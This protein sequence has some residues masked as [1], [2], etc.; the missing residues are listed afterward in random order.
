[1][2][3][4][5]TF[6]GGALALS[7]AAPQRI[8]IG[9]QSIERAFEIRDAKVRTVS[10]ENKRTHRLYPVESS[11]FELKLAWER[12]GYD[13]GWE[14]PVTLTAKD[15]TLASFDQKPG[16]VVF[17]LSN[18]WLSIEADLTYTLAENDFF[19]RKQLAVRSA[20]RDTHFIEEI[21]LESMRLAGAA[22]EHGGFGQPLYAGDLFM[23]V[24]YPG[25][26]NTASDGKVRIWY[27]GGQTTSRTAF[28]TERAVVGAAGPGPVRTSFMEY[29]DRIRTGPVRPVTVFNTWYDMQH[30]MLTDAKALDRMSTLK[31]KLLDPFGLHLDTFV[32]DD[33]WDLHDKL[34]Q[35]H[36][37]RFQGD[38]SPLVKGLAGQ[39]TTL[40]LWYGPIGG[41]HT[42]REERLAAGR[43]DGYE[44]T[45]GGRY[46]CLAGPRYR[47]RF[48]NSVLD[49]VRRYHVTHF[50]FDGMS[51]GCNDPSH[52]HLLGVHSR[53][54]GLRAFIDVLK[55]IKAEDRR[56]FLNITTSIWLSPWWLEYS[57]VVFMGGLD[58][59]FLNNVPAL[60]ERE[61]AITYRDKVFYD[62]F[63]KYAYQFPQNS[64]MTIGIIKGTLGHEGGLGE[65]LASFTNNAIMNYSRGVMMTELYL[66]PSIITDPEWRALGGVMK[67]GQTN[68][69]VLLHDTRFIG[70]DPAERSIY[71]YAHFREGRGIVTLRNPVIE[72]QTYKLALGESSGV[73]DRSRTYRARVIYPFTA[74]LPGE[75]RYGDAPTFTLEGFEVQVIEFSADAFP[76]A[77]AAV[78]TPEPRFE[79]NAKSFNLTLAEPRR[80]AVLCESNGQLTP[81]LRANGQ[82]L[83]FK[84]VGPRTG[85]TDLSIGGG[86]WTFL[87]AELPAGEHRIEMDLPGATSAA[88]YLVAPTPIAATPIPAP[89]ARARRVVHLFTKY[90]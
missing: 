18:K 84:T 89:N 67:W 30:E 23:G 70:G 22:F 55:A 62:N 61:K 21:A 40:G 86:G 10:I 29:V 50:K 32:L 35:I 60:T 52:G 49:M 45:S 6:I 66:S 5:T 64:L 34:W 16:A 42:T 90:W 7:A 48:K 54:A 38:F 27:Y 37:T 43:R 68:A 2:R 4:L 80:L 78:A 71:G 73:M 65:T 14:N 9:N 88:A 75:Y 77:P 17:H 51:F 57:D 41:Y 15:F 44:I 8:A 74:N 20:G 3:L 36:P 76:A 63:R 47:E 53:E 79:G 33:G 13:H 81:R 87:V 25:G 46:F 85:Q 82:N 31:A 28:T 72:S 1:M 12:A 39:G 11:E 59:G 69:G 24:E 26:Y 56:V 58:Y 83:E 19:L